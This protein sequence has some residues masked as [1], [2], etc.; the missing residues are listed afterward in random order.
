MFGRRPATPVSRPSSGSNRMRRGIAFG[1]GLAVAVSILAPVGA[2]A[3]DAKAKQDKQ[4]K[5]KEREVV[6]RTERTTTYRNPDG[7]FT[8]ESH[9]G[10]INYKDADGTWKALDAKLRTKEG[11]FENGAGPLR[12]SFAPKASKA[13]IVEVRGAGWSV[14]FG[15][16]GAAEGKAKLDDHGISYPEVLPGIDLDYRM[17][18]EG[19]KEF[20]VLKE[21]PT[22]A[23]RLRF[24][25][26]LKGVTM[27]ALEDDS[28]G[29]FDGN[30]AEV[31]HVPPGL[32][33]DS[34]GDR[35]RGDEPARTPVSYEV[36]ES[37]G[38]PVLEV[39]VDSSWLIDPA[40]VAPIRIDPQ[41]NAG[42]DTAGGDAYGRSD[43]PNTNFN[44][45][46]QTDDGHSY[47]NKI[48]YN[49][50]EFVSVARFDMGPA[51]NK[52][53]IS[54]TWNGYFY[55]ANPLHQVIMWRAVNDWNENTVTFNNRPNHD[56]NN[57]FLNWSGTNAWASH[58]VTDW[59]QHWTTPNDWAN[60][61]V[62]YDMGGQSGY[63][64]L[65]SD[66]MSCCGLDSF[67]LVN[68]QEKPPTINW[69]TDSPDPVNPGG[70]VTFTVNWSDPF[71]QAKASCAR[72][73]SRPT[74]TARRQGTAG[75]WAASPPTAL[76]RRAT[77]PPTPNGASRTRTTPSRATP[78][79]RA[80][81]RSRA[82]SS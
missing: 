81:R 52:T 30:G 36:T 43:Q 20:V 55:N 77:P 47:K 56:G 32:A 51:M 28:I 34:S 46:F 33:F 18:A 1:I 39:V 16:D 79:A 5:P 11:R 8:T 60:Q 35:S 59:V 71:D 29:F 14:G 21:R 70:T 3:G 63:Y 76:P 74:A 9:A 40:R 67:I 64:E 82:A 15:L 24:P 49:G 19:V 62:V 50:P 73:T 7:S 44:G 17:T 45:G 27:R 78:R 31:A 23:P 6:D 53:I 65:A 58:D 26:K 4:E 54:G 69:A 25:L 12:V 42:R 80:R 48:G 68:W 75:V 37:D 72:P 13:D 10:K 66:E 41:F 61:G 38:G 2:G 57:K 22:S